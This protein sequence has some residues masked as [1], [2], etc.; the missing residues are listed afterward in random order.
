MR[1]SG[2]P[3]VEFAAR[4]IPQRGPGIP[5][6]DSARYAPGPKA[7]MM[8]FWYSLNSSGEMK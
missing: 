3:S 7:S 6:P 2:H 8:R 1:G 5:R 4:Q